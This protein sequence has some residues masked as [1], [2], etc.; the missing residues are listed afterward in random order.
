MAILVTAN[1][2]KIQAGQICLW[3]ILPLLCSI[4][5][6]VLFTYSGLTS[7]SSCCSHCTVPLLLTYVKSQMILRHTWKVLDGYVTFSTY[8]CILTEFSPDKS[9]TKKWSLQGQYP[10]EVS[11]KSW[12][13]S[14]GREGGSSC[15]EKSFSNIDLFF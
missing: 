12:N 7:L 3:H 5:F 4:F 9:L 14:P 11:A 8:C 2:M 10:K 13:S 15:F 6:L 1:Y